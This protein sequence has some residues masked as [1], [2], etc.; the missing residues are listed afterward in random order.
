MRIG[1]PVPG[2]DWHTHGGDDTDP[3]LDIRVPDGN[4]LCRSGRWGGGVL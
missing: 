3:G 4:P 2:S 1:N